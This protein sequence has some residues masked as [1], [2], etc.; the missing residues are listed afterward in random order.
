MLMIL[1]TYDQDYEVILVGL[2][3]HPYEIGFYGSTTFELSGLKCMGTIL[4][5]GMYKRVHCPKP[6]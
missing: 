6:L 3:K 4:A 2:I 5:T 1:A